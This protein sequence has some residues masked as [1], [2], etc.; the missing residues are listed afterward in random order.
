MT[1]MTDLNDRALLHKLGYAQELQRS[2][3]TFSNFAVSFT[4]ISVLAGT[5]TLYGFVMSTGG[6]VEMSIGWPIVGLFVILVGMAMAEV[7]SSYPTSGGL[8]YWTARLAGPRKAPVWSWFTGWFNLVGQ[9]GITAGIDFGLAMFI[10][11]FLAIHFGIP[12]TPAH[13]VEIFAIVLVLHAILNT[14]GVKVIALI[15]DISV[16]WHVLGV[17]IIVALLVFIPSHHQSAKFVFTATYNGTGWGSMVYVLLIGLLMAQYTFTGYDASAHMSEETKNAAIAAPRGIV[18]SIVISLI[19]GWILLLAV[20]FAIQNYGGEL[21]SPTGVPPFQIFMDALGGKLATFLEVI[22]IAAQFF[23]GMA[24]ITANSRMIYAF[25]RDGAVPGHRI[26][27]KINKKSRTPVNAVILAVIA[28]FLLGVP[29]L[30]SPTAYGAVTSIAVIGLY[31]AYGI[32]VLLRVKLGKRFMKGPW[33]LGRWGVPIG[34]IAIIWVVFITILFV[35]PETYPVT[36]D[37]FNYAPVAVGAVIV[38]AGGYWLFSA[39]KWFKGPKVQG[40]EE[41]LAEIEKELG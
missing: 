30:W 33:N 9:F 29:Y 38:F 36:I 27:H 22:I 39:R 21:N 25:S 11:A 2:M 12:V 18:W 40:T 7:C 13:D 28:A 3:K 8:Y 14:F 6:P 17:L 24:S 4:I 31:I 1:D 37:S 35:L 15:N 41:E 10:A 19:A 34:I 32:P 16:W 26:W 5:M 23:C 20:T